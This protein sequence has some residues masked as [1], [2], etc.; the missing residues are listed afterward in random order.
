MPNGLSNADAI[1]EKTDFS[2][3]FSC[4]L[5]KVPVYPGDLKGA[6]K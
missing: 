5:V 2:L 6:V 1:Q 3:T 4:I